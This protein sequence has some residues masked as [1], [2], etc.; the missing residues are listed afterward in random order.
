MSW[1]QADHLNFEKA[2]HGSDNQNQRTKPSAPTNI[3]LYHPHAL[4]SL[5]GNFLKIAFLRRQASS[6]DSSLSSLLRLSLHL[7]HRH[8]HHRT[9][10]RVPSY[11]FEFELEVVLQR[12]ARFP[13]LSHGHHGGL[14]RPGQQDSAR[15]HGPRRPRRRPRRPPYPLGGSSLRRRRRRPGSVSLSLVACICQY[16]FVGFS[17]WT[18][19]FEVALWWLVSWL[20]FIDAELG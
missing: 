15:L 4:T 18:G 19:R 11:P 16:M 20:T 14:D 13:C 8:R 6:E 5:W 12:W 3:H 9:R 10:P 2:A 7:R 17:F 1:P